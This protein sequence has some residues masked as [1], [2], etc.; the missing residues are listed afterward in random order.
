MVDVPAI[1]V[2]AVRGPFK[3]VVPREVLRIHNGL[4]VK[5]DTEIKQNF[6]RD[7]RQRFSW[8]SPVTVV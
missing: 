5:P 4:T 6:Y 2:T 7:R 1:S 8:T 3:N